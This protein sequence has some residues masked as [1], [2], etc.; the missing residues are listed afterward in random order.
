MARVL[1]P[2]AALAALAALAGC[3]VQSNVPPWER[4]CEG[5]NCRTANIIVDCAG[6]CEITVRVEEVGTDRFAQ[7]GPLL[8]AL[9]R[10]EQDVRYYTGYALEIAVGIK[11]SMRDTFQCRILDGPGNEQQS[12]GSGSR[13]CLLVTRQ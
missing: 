7:T 2:L 5:P 9:G 13:A 10:Y 11:G 6:P 8:V 4:G 3:P 12:V 1:R